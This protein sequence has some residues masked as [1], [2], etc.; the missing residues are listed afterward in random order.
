M[1]A[2]F[3][4]SRTYIVASVIGILSA[5][6]FLGHIDNTTFQTFIALLTGG[7]L[8]TLRAAVPP[9]STPDA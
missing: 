4:G 6:H 8:A 1:F 9:S 5:L 7:G 3:K 2:Q